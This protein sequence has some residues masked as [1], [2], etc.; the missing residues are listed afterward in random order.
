M[1]TKKPTAKPVPVQ[2]KAYSILEVMKRAEEKRKAYMTSIAHLS[3]EEQQNKIE[4]DNTLLDDAY[5]EYLKAG[6]AR[7]T[8]ISF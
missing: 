3:P 7:L 5:A 1:A 4:A 8:R 6:G 2:G